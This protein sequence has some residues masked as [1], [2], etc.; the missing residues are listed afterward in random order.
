M[1]FYNYNV[2]R[3]T[4][5]LQFVVLMYILWKHTMYL[6]TSCFI[7]FYIKNIGNLTLLKKLLK[8]AYAGWL[9]KMV[10]QVV[11]REV[12]ATFFAGLSRPTR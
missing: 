5:I 12:M 2:I 9:V 11:L 4:I 10:K 3:K 7:I 8:P 1:Q 6:N